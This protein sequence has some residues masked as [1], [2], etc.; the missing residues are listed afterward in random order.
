M[1]IQSATPTAETIAAPATQKAERA[2]GF[3]LLMSGIRCIIVYA[4][5]PFVLPL[6]GMTTQVTVGVSLMIDVAALSALLYSVRKFWRIDYRYKRQY[7]AIAVVA[8]LV[9]VAFIA[10]D[11]AVLLNQ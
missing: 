3:S 1:S 4:I 2:F 8:G 9:L 10:L 6:L 5:L 11:I 7:T